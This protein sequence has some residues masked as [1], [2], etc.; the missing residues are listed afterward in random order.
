MSY[1][2]CAP[3]YQYG[4]QLVSNQR[5]SGRDWN[6]IEGDVRRDWE[7]RNPGTWDRMK[8]AVRYGWER[9]KEKVS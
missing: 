2:Q 5:Y 7:T 1:E 4:S 8:N 9:V 3:A 6:A